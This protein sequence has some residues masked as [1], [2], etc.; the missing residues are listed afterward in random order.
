MNA[1]DDR[2]RELQAAIDQAHA[3]AKAKRRVVRPVP[4]GIGGWLIL[5]AIGNLITPFLMA[6]SA[7]ENAAV[8]GQL[9]QN[10]APTLA[11]VLGVEV[12]FNA[13]LA[14]AWAVALVYL[15]G[16]NRRYPRM[17]IVLTALSA[18]GVIGDPLLASFA[19]NVSLTAEDV[20]VLTRSVVFAAIWIPYMMRSRRVRETFTGQPEG[21]PT[22]AEID[23]PRPSDRG[24]GSNSK[25][26]TFSY[27][28]AKWRWARNGAVIGFLITA[29]DMLF[30][31]R[32]VKVYPW[33]EP[34][35]IAQ[36]IGM[37]MGA[38]GVAAVIA[39][40]LGA[41]RDWFA[42]SRTSTAVP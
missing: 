24:Y 37:F 22:T 33:N 18:A 2:M 42:R 13:A 34:G 25:G 41:L 5:V 21:R 36:N 6:K 32:G 11:A 38:T 10:T 39:F 30:E 20:G 23:P 7:Y 17:F 3:E 9:G 12:L 28:A 1:E 19:F 29:T 31:W 4:K 40:G 14:I 26:G 8:L 35:Y 15:L 16:R 27:Q